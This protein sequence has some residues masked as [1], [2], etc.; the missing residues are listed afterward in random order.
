VCSDKSALVRAQNEAPKPDP[1]SPWIRGGHGFL[2]ATLAGGLTAP[3]VGAAQFAVRGGFVWNGLQLLVEVSPGTTLF[4]DTL[5]TAPFGGFDVTANIGALIPITQAVAWILRVGG[6]AGFLY[7]DGCCVIANPIPMNQTP[8]F[9]EVRLDL[10]GVAV[11][12][13]EHVV[14]ELL[15]PSVR[16][17]AG[18][19]LA[20]SEFIAQWMVAMSVEYLF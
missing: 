19:R 14:I 1:I 8:V 13:G 12:A 9:G 20:T 16:L 4:N 6:G 10:L 5:R 3:G 2:G 18:K 15:I 11:R 17:D 7:G